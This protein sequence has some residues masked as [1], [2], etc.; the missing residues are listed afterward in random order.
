MLRPPGSAVALLDDA[1]VD[2]HGGV[3][4]RLRENRRRP[5]ASAV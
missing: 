1:R 3:C 4:E 2:L 5:I